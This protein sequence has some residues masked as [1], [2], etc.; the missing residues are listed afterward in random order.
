MTDR[1]PST[2]GMPLAPSPARWERLRRPIAIMIPQDIRPNT[3][4][5]RPTQR[6]HSIRVWATLAT[7]VGAVAQGLSWLS[8]QPTIPPPPAAR[9]TE[10]LADAA[11]NRVDRDIFRLL[12]EGGSG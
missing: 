11:R 9:T 3:P 7:A 5:A 12:R 6:V 2:H 4:P 10:A 1:P 8:P